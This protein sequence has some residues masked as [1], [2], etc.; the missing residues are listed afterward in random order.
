MKKLLPIL[1]PNGYKKEIELFFKENLGH[2]KAAPVIAFGFDEGDMISYESAANSIDYENRFESI[3]KQAFENLSQI[4]INFEVQIFEGSKIAFADRSEYASE[5]ILDPVFLHKLE[6]SLETSTLMIGVPFKGLLVAVD[7]NSE[8]RFKFPHVVQQYFNNPE[9][10]I[11]SPHVFLV[12]NGEVIGM[13]GE[14]IENDASF[15][16]S[17]NVST[18]N[19]IVELNSDSIENLVLDVNKSYQQI[20]LMIMERK[21]FGGEI[22]Y[23]LSNELKLN[24]VFTEKCK[25]IVEQIRKNEMAQNI[26]KVTTGK[27]LEFKFFSNNKLIAPKVEVQNEDF[28]HYSLQDLENIY[29]EIISIPNARTNITAL[30]K[31]TMLIEEYEKRGIPMPGEKQ[32]EQETQ[33]EPSKKW[34]Q[35]WKPG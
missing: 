26:I 27:S 11:I 3:K 8:I 35:F 16:I 28:S 25:N 30:T 32:I 24:D 2:L 20:L 29:Y 1:K 10:D 9:Q 18:N 22:Q 23:H 4:E 6:Q 14:N 17:E 12:K 21:F 19:Y 7:S 15:S 31:M 33:Y 13:A 5:K 34:W